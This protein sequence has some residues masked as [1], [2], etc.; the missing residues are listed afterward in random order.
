MRCGRRYCGATPRGSLREAWLHTSSP[1][2]RQLGLMQVPGRVLSSTYECSNAIDIPVPSASL[3]SRIRDG[4]H[5]CVIS[6]TLSAE[7]SSHGHDVG[8]RCSIDCDL[9]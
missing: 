5:V 1:A 9:T 3:S 2:S 6:P 8:G 4:D 7:K